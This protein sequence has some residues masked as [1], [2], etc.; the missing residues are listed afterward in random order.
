[1]NP[2]YVL[3]DWR[4]QFKKFVEI[5]EPTIPAI[6]MYTGLQRYFTQLSLISWMFDMPY[7]YSAAKMAMNVHNKTTKTDMRSI[8]LCYGKN[9]LNNE[10]SDLNSLPLS[11]LKKL[12]VERGLKLKNYYILPKAKLLEFLSMPELPSRYKI[13]KMTIVEL[14][15]LAKQRKL[16]GFW[17]LNKQ[18]LTNVLFPEDDN[19]IENTS[20]HQHEKN[21]GKTSK[22]QDPENQ[23]TDKV[24]V[25]LVK[26]AGEQGLDNM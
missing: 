15:D 1:M 24:G 6:G 16:R 22:H 17:G 13:E 8:L 9:R 3:T 20:T 21:D 5:S 19:A 25:E 7:A 14:R 23:D 2:A 11:A 26:N 4:V 12:V 18:Q 10:M